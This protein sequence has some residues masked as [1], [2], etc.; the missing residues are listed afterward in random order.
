M[1]HKIVYVQYKILNICNKV[2]SNIYIAP[3]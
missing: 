1:T 2:Q 3:V